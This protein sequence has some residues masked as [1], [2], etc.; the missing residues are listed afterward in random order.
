MVKAVLIGY[1]EVGKGVFGAIQE[2]HEIYIEDPQYGMIAP[3][4]LYDL[5]L[6]AIP[7][8]KN[9][10]EIVK[11]YSLTHLPKAIVVFST[12]PIGTCRLVG[13]LHSPIEGKHDNMAVSIRVHTRW[14]AGHDPDGVVSQFFR[15]AGLSIH[16]VK[17]PEITE[18]L[19]LASTAI[20]GINIEWARYCKEMADELGFNFD[21]VKRYNYDYN[22]LVQKVHKNRN[23]VRYNLD[24]PVG[25][26][27]GHCVRQNLPLLAAKKPHPFIQGVLDL[28]TEDEN[29]N[30]NHQ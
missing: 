4:E 21:L 22:F 12:V 10:A 14:I 25:I 11:K 9:F 23:L 15:D 28:N 6:V 5:M 3:P 20:Y 19:K 18:F 1:G 2:Q 30:C 8:S 7:Y 29:E 17:D 16:A 26:I 13:A 24:A 27:G